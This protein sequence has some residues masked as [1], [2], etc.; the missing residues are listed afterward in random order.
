MGEI[1]L[2]VSVLEEPD[3][4]GVNAVPQDKVPHQQTRVDIPDF[5]PKGKRE[6]ICT[7][8]DGNACCFE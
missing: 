4:I 8:E 1:Q 7:T 2:Q 3:G 5:E 6:G